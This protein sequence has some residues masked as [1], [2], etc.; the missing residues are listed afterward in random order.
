M[1]KNLG[2]LGIVVLGFT[3]CE[4]NAGTKTELGALPVSDFSYT[5]VDSNTIALTSESTGDPFMFQWEIA[6]LGSFTGENVEVLIPLTG[7]YDITHT[8]FNQGG[9]A[10]SM[11]QVEIF[12][13]A[14]LP[15]VGAIEYLTECSS[16]T[17]KLAPEEGACWVAPDAN[18]FWWQN[19]TADVVTRSCLF[20]D[21]WV[22]HEDGTMEYK[23]N[24][25]I[26]GEPYMGLSAESCIAESALPSAVSAWGSGTHTFEIIPATADHPDQLRVIGTGAFMGFPKA[27]NGQEVSSPVNEVTYDILYMTDQNNNRYM[28]IEVNYTAGIWRFKFYSES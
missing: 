26:W 25:D 19:S 22:F 6:G 14:D 21:E 9:H 10:S 17:W 7:T 20:N 3:A 13:D 16:R 8:V 4:P 27:A 2:L 5:M 11:D 18:G 12:K 24:G 28:Q 1:L 23:T 15:C